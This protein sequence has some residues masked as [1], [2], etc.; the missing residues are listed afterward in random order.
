MVVTILTP[1][2]SDRYDATWIEIH[3]HDGSLIIQED[4]APM[5]APLLNAGEIL[6]SLQ[7]GKRLTVPVSHGIVHIERAAITFLLY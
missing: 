4:H 2:S 3:L 5:I 6:L 1:S 7:D